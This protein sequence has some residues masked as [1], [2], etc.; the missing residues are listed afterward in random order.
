MSTM[1]K[2]PFAPP[3]APTLALIERYQDHGDIA[4]R[5]RLL[6]MYLPIVGKVVAR[7]KGAKARRDDAVSAGI[8]GLF[9]AIRRYDRTKSN[10]FG[11]YAYLWVKAAILDFLRKDRVVADVSRTGRLVFARGGRAAQALMRK[12]L[13]PTPELIADELGVSREHT[14]T[15]LASLSPIASIDLP[16]DDLHERYAGTDPPPDAQLDRTRRAGDIAR[17]VALLPPRERAIIEARY[18]GDDDGASLRALAE[19]ALGG[20][21]RERV[22]QIEAR[23]LG[24]LRVLLAEYQDEA[25]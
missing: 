5:D 1:T 22:R 8:L 13:E 16:G 20:I 2:K 6:A 15:A 10:S 11:G 14:A 9:S 4:A 23:A 7:Y 12:G 17:A 3:H 19:G 18:L 25:A 24:R 21:S